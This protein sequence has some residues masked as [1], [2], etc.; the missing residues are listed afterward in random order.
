MGF[1]L[2]KIVNAVQNLGLS[3]LTK[4]HGSS[5]IRKGNYAIYVGES[6]RNRFVIPIAYL[7][8]P[9]FKDLLSQAE[10]EFGYDHP[11]GGLTIPCNDDT[12]IDFV[13]RLNEL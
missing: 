6:Q 7:H 13:S 3:S 1:R 9:Y 5:T 4:K 11:M 12:F 2:A 10:E 8:R